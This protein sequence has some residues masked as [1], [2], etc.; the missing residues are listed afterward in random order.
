MTVFAYVHVPKCAGSTIDHHVIRHL[1]KDQYWITKRRHWRKPVSTETL[2]NVLFLS[3][4]FLRK[5]VESQLGGKPLRRAILLREPTSF[6]LSYYNYRMMRY[7]QNGWKPYSFDLHLRS[8]PDDAITHFI[9]SRWLELSWAELLTLDPAK[10]WEIVN[11]ELS[12]FWYVGDYT[13]CN[14]LCSLISREIGIP[15]EFERANTSAKWAGQTH[16]APL[17]I[18][19]LSENQIALVNSKS[20]LDLALWTTWRDART[21]VAGVTPRS[22]STPRS[23]LLTESLRPIFATR[24]R[25]QRGWR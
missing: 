19:A 23:F 10:K 14:E 16:W 6:H 7:I 1:N 25:L 18:D 21:N 2:S 24:R 20:Q 22:N 9:L 17:T 12:S 13:N 8:Q 11:N 3:G 5:S 15:E 4:H